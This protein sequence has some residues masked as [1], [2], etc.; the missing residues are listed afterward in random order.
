MFRKR[1]L[2]RF[3]VRLQLFRLFSQ[4][5][6][7]LRVGY[8]VPNPRETPP[9]LQGDA[10]GHDTDRNPPFFL[11]LPHNIWALSFIYYHQ[12]RV[13]TREFQ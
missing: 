2:A 4:K 9:Q 13:N 3:I 7:Q 5:V 11:Q 1:C 12:I 10:L 6:E 8:H